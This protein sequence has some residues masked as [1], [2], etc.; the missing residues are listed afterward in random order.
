MGFT[1]GQEIEVGEEKFG[2]HMINFIS[3]NGHIEQT[4]ALRPEEL[5]RICL[6]K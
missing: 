6:G 5:G 1:S 4:V 3:P 2:L